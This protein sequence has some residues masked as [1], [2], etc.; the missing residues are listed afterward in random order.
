MKP[1]VFLCRSMTNDILEHIK[2]VIILS[3]NWI[4]AKE[5]GV[6]KSFV[7]VVNCQSVLTSY[8]VFNLEV[9]VSLFNYRRG[10]IISVKESDI[11]WAIKVLSADKGF[12]SRIVSLSLTF[13]DVTAIFQVATEGVLNIDIDNFF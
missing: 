1:S 4:T 9:R 11:E 3:G 10:Q 8:R 13:K 2:R 7:S 6:Y 5:Y 12:M